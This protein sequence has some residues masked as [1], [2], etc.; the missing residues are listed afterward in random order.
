MTEPSHTH[1]DEGEDHAMRAL[2]KRALGAEALSTPDILRGV[3]RRLGKRQRK[4]FRHEGWST[5]A[6]RTSYVLVALLTLLAVAFTYFAIS[7]F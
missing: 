1:E 7:R 6:A 5:S 2:L 3:Q 4:I